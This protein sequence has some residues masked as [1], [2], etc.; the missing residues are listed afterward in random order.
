MSTGVHQLPAA[1]RIAIASSRCGHSYRLIYQFG[2]R[3]RIQADT[4]TFEI[5]APGFPE[6][7]R[8]GVS[9][10]T[11]TAPLECR[12]VTWACGPSF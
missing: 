6:S 8:I 4:Q 11:A 7:I 3:M 10:V 2:A 5:V 12:A 1:V 9:V